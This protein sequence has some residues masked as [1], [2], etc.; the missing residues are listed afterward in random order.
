MINKETYMYKTFKEL[1]NEFWEEVENANDKARGLLNQIAVRLDE[2]EDDVVE[3]DKQL[4]FN[5]IDDM[6]ND[7][8]TLRDD[9]D[10]LMDKSTGSGQ[11]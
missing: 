9:V 4:R 11:N 1:L 5:D 2:I 7:I 10:E 8:D 3:H 6:K